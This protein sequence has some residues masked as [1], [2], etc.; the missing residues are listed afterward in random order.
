MS[1]SVE[2]GY[3][4]KWFVS[5][6][7]VACGLGA[8]AT[9]VGGIFVWWP[10]AGL[11]LVPLGYGAYQYLIWKNTHY[12]ITR[13]FI[14]KRHGILFEHRDEIPVVAILKRRYLLLIPGAD[15]GSISLETAAQSAN[16]I[17]SLEGDLI[18]A[19]IERLSE[20]YELIG[21]LMQLAKLKKQ[22]GGDD[23]DE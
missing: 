18:L 2:F 19:N 14:I 12:T 20:V 11:C 9:V 17:H 6:I 4:Y 7:L 21:E 1:N 15:V 23:H 16:N 8:V 3:S 22:R 13:E 5:P 10:L